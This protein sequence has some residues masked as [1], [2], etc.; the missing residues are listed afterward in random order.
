M[1]RP[2]HSSPRD[3]ASPQYLLAQHAARISKSEGDGCFQQLY[4]ELDRHLGRPL[5]SI[6]QPEPVNGVETS[7]RNISNGIVNSKYHNRISKVRSQRLTR[8]HSYLLTNG[9]RHDPETARGLPQPLV[10]GNINDKQI[11][12]TNRST[13]L[14][15]RLMP[16]SAFVK[17]LLLSS[18]LSRPRYFSSGFLHIFP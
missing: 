16:F 14:S 17:R 15:H 13:R 5:P 7:P 1:L 18:I 12:E 8:K 2:V 11:L 10:S 6:Q 3:E 9:S 4:K